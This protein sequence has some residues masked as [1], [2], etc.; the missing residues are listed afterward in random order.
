MRNKIK[1]KMGFLLL[2]LILIFTFTAC[3]VSSSNVDEKQLK[4]QSKEQSGTQKTDTITDR[5]GNPMKLPEKT[6]KIV[7]MAPS[8]TQTLVSLGLGEQIVAADKYSAEIEGLR[9]DIPIFD[10]MSPDT[11]QLAVLKPDIIFA[12]GMSKAGG[13]DPFKPIT[14][15][16]VLMTYIPSSTSI[17][18][19]KADIHF[20]G[21]VTNTKEKADAVIIG[22]ENEI[23]S[24]TSKIKD[25]GLHKK[26]YFEI[27]SAPD[28]YSFGRDT[29]LT[30]MIE[31]LSGENIL[32]DQN[33][34]VPIS[35]EVVIAANPDIIFTNVNYIEDPVGEIKSRNGWD[36]INAVKENQVYAI[37][38][39]SSSQPNENIILAFK[40]MARAMYPDLFHE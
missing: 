33:G 7:S 38:N 5:E 25:S 26:V 19:I 12:T 15:M 32:A 4:E 31:M 9:A 1:N 11:E 30:E 35:E 23:N 14:D 24:I 36:V 10:I 18:E 3:N 2:T 8:I 39:N 28:L 6:D 40:Q 29:F 17:E 20:L 34:W 22:M 13:D 21:E 16:G 37:D 27:A